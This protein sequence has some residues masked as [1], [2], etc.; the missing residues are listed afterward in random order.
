MKIAGGRF[1]RTHRYAAVALAL[2]CLIPLFGSEQVLASGQESYSRA[3][4][5]LP[6]DIRERGLTFAGAR[7]PIDRSDVSSRVT[8]Q[9]NY[10][11]M[12]RRA[13]T[14]QWFDRMSVYGPL[15][16]PILIEKKIPADFLYVATLLSGLRPTAKTQSGGVGWWALSPIKGKKDF[17][18]AQWIVNDNWDDRR[19]PARSTKIACTILHGLQKRS[20][21]SDW[22]MTICA[23][24]D[25]L[26][27][28]E[29]V[30]RKAKGYSYWDMVMPPY[31]EILIPRLVALKIIDTHREFYGVEVPALSRLSFDLLDR[32]KLSKDLPLYIIAK[33]C[34][35]NP[36]AIW[37]LNPGVDPS[38]GILPAADKRSV[39]G[40]PL[41]V[42]KGMGQKT[43]RLLVREGYLPN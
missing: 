39:A 5:I 42:P 22:V 15:I 25:S 28:I 34:S 1:L 41:R 18:P 10:L 11:L 40:F 4:Y 9:I 14:M 3:R 32:L 30:V 37:E 43:K 20:N 38:T 23:Y 27:K 13:G 29:A 16:R 35:T 26:D 21:S 12:D 7:I 31:S 24:V 19:D 33:C 8:E 17:S 2:G 6:E 36:R